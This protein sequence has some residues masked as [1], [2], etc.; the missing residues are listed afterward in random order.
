MEILNCLNL[1]IYYDV[2]VRD[3]ANPWPHRYILQDIVQAFMTMGLFFPNVEVTSIV[4][5]HPGSREGQAFRNSKI[6]DPEARRQVR[7]DA[8]TRTSCA[9]RP[10]KFWDGWE[11]KVYTGD[12]LYIDKFPFDWNMAI[13]PIIAKFY[14]AGMIG[15]ACVEPRP[16][17][18]P[19]FATANTE[20]HRPDK[21]DLF[22]MYSSTDEF[23]QG[24]PPSFI[25]YRDWP[26][27]LPAARRFAAIY[28]TKTPRFAL[29]RL[30]SAP[31]FYPLMMLLPMRQAVSFLD[32]VRRAWECSVYSKGRAHERMECTQHNDVAARVPS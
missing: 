21:L 7:P 28:K 1:K 31:H 27:L 5:E 24:M 32:P 14:R 8:R 29:L 23:V 13:R 4:Q 2:Y 3:P 25:D 30:W 15:P 12:D 10:R 20:Q 22:I 16:D 18:V 26:E 11:N 6:L 9:Y 19:G 17:V